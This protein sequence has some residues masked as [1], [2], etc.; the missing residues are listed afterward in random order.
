MSEIE[1]LDDKT[2]V[3]FFSFLIKA[4][5]WG[6]IIYILAKKFAVGEFWVVVGYPSIIPYD[7]S[8]AKYLGDNLSE[9]DLQ[10]LIRG[11][12][13]YSQVAGPSKSGGSASPVIPIYTVKF[14]SRDY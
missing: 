11:L 8:N 5:L 13:K 4:I 7:K 9:E 2:A 10:H 12:V 1:Q 3:N 14:T 6:L